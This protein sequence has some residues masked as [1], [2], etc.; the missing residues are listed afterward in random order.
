MVRNSHD[1]TIQSQICN[2]SLQL[3]A[4]EICA[5]GTGMFPRM[6]GEQLRVVGRFHQ[7]KKMPDNNNLKQQLKFKNLF[8]EEDKESETTFTNFGE[9]QPRKVEELLPTIDILPDT[10]I[11]YP[12]GGY[13]PFYGVPNTLPRYQQKIWPYVKRIKFHERYRYMT[14]K[15]R[16][17]VRRGA[18]R[19]GQDLSQLNPH[20]HD[21]YLIICLDRIGRMLKNDYTRPKKNGGHVSH[22]APKKKM[23][24][25]HRLVALAWIPNPAEAEHAMHKNDDRTNYLIE[26]LKWGTQRE[27]SKGKTRRFPDTREQQY[28]NLVDKGYIKG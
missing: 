16:D 6:A 24:R 9:F 7:S 2:T 25:L 22:M 5:R 15:K 27:N 10:Y 20:L 26:N 18:L 8:T 4:Q 28:L 13:H 19:K 17:N 12:S 14:I 1:L 23:V 3:R 21:G 11:I